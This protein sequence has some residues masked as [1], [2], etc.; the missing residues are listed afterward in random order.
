[1]DTNLILN[2]VVSLFYGFI[3]SPFFL[4]LKLILAIY[5]TVLFADIIML[6]SIRGFGSDIK[7]SFRGTNIPLMS[8][9]KTRKKWNKIEA[10]LESGDYSQNKIAIIEADKIVDGIFV[11]MGLKGNDM[12]ERL[13]TLNP[14]Q[15]EAEEDLEKAH[16][17]RNQIINDSSF[18][19]EKK[20][21]KE[22]LDIYA[23][24]LTENEF[25]E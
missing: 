6:L 24:F 22:T 4:T 15:L 13:K 23:K 19:I 5:T 25:M 17:I 11:S 16:K 10:R 2:L 14:E 8:A 20:E 1:M 21:A 7:T 9:K 3:H 18:N 12:V